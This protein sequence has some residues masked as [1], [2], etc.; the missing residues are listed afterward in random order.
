MVKLTV[1]FSKRPKIVAVDLNMWVNPR[2]NNINYGQYGTGQPNLDTHAFGNPIRN[3][4]GSRTLY[5]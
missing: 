5:K 4:M 2:F 1:E 3:S